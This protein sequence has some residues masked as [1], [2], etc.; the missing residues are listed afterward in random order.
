MKEPIGEQVSLDFYFSQLSHANAM[1]DT[2]VH[3][4]DSGALFSGEVLVIE[5]ED[6]RNLDFQ[7]MSDEII[8]VKTLSDEKLLD[9]LDDKHKRIL[10]V[11]LWNAI[12]IAEDVPEIVTYN[13]ISEEASNHGNTNPI[14]IVSEGWRINTERNEHDAIKCGRRCY[15][16]FH[17]VCDA[18]IPDY[19][20]ILNENSLSCPFDLKGEFDPIYGNAQR[21]F[22][23]FFISEQRYGTQSL[24]NIKGMYSDCYTER[25]PSGL[26]VSTLEFY[27]PKRITLD[28]SEALKRSIEV[29]KIVSQ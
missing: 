13:S 28:R 24:D 20:A 11:G 15:K 29:A 19:A 4:L 8:S 23:E 5:S 14:S 25:R 1:R 12:G 22:C 17:R 7:Y 6:I 3:C 26:Y 10:K 27:N 2:V 18:L 21:L 16:T 9:W